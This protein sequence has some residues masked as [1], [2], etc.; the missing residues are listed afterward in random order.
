MLLWIMLAGV[1]G[2]CGLLW[3]RL[4]RAELPVALAAPVAITA[5]LLGQLP[6]ISRGGALAERRG[7]V[8]ALD[9]ELAFRLDGLS[10][11]F[12]LLIAGIGALII[13][14]TAG[15]LHGNRRRRRFYLYLLLFMAS[16]LGVVLADNVLLLFV[17]W[18]LTSFTSYLLIGFDHEN[19]AARK[20]ALQALLVTGV[21]GLFLLGGVLLMGQAVGSMQVSTLVAS[22]DLLRAHPH[23][24]WMLALVLVGAFTKSAQVPFHFWLPNAMVAPTPASAYLHSSTMVKAGVYLLAR[25]QPALGGTEAWATSVT[26]IGALTLLVGSIMA[27]GQTPLKRLLA[28]TTVAALGGMTMLLGLGPPAAPAAMAYLLAH[29]LYKAALFL[30]AG[31]IDHET[32]EKS[33]DRLGGLG[34][35]MPLTALAGIVAAVS[36]A[37]LPPAF[38]FVAKE[39]VLAAAAVHAALPWIMVASSALML[40][41]GVLTGVRPFLGARRQT[42]RAPHEAP[43]S[44]RLGPLVLGALAL[45]FGLVPGSLDRLLGA[46]A[47]AIAGQPAHPHFALWH[48]W[49]PE[50]WLSLATLA[51]G[52][53]ALCAVPRLRTITAAASPLAR[54]SGPERGYAAAL[55]GLNALAVAQTRLL[56]SGSLRRYLHVTILTACVLIALASAHC[57]LTLRPQAMQPVSLAQGVLVLLVV[58]PALVAVVSPSRLGAIAAMGVVGFCIALLFVYGAAPDLAMTLLAVEALTVVLLVSAFYHLPPITVRSRRG[59]IGQDAFIALL[60]G[61][62]MTLLTLISTR[63]QLAPPISEY[64]ARTSVSLGHGRNIVNV[65]LVDYRGLDTL[66]E[67]TV[68]AVAALGAFALLKLRLGGQGRRR[69][70]EDSCPL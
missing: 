23:Y 29:A 4:G 36:M 28:Y 17:C 12:A 38:G 5:W 15:Y 24:P 67:I 32:G 40:V 19:A 65:I 30:V 44:M 60:A 16:M 48:G 37:G 26:G 14:Y 54:R 33:V 46:A 13:C 3:P 45:V 7:W 39:S 51:L 43:W 66:G 42:P 63:I 49:S 68:L 58:V 25:L 2:A 53:A 57:G 56:Q 62:A 59:S 50:L 34:R 55:D 70:K 61:A 1:V 11:L 6:V 35:A 47:S 21:G 22:G 10:L 9:L 18:E 8:P 31:A 69:P 41:V 52:L 64:F 20:A 27:V